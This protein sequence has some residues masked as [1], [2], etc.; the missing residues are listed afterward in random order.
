M[1]KHLLAL[2]VA[3]LLAGCIPLTLADSLAAVP[4]SQL[5]G[6]PII[7][8]AANSPLK[9][10]VQVNNVSRGRG[11]N[12]AP[13]YVVSDFQQALPQSLSAQGILAGAGAQYRLDAAVLE[14]KQPTFGLSL[15]VT[16]T[17]RYKVTEVATDRVTFDQTI[18]VDYTAAFFDAITAA[19]RGRLAYAG[20]IRD[21]I[22]KFLDQLIGMLGGSGTG[23][24]GALELG[25]VG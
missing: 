13:T 14:V 20:S 16:S 8:L 11:T 7:P 2:C 5:I 9:Q 24:I 22:S 23:P 12:P 21:N 17:V 18:T 25:R 1:F 19:H 10:S 4:R 15:T 3:A 6:T